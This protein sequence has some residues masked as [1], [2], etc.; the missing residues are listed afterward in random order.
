M[1]FAFEV[2]YDG[3]PNTAVARHRSPLDIRVDSKRGMPI[4]DVV[5]LTLQQRD[6][7]AA[8]AMSYVSCE[9]GHA[10]ARLITD[11]HVTMMSTHSISSETRPMTVTL[12]PLSPR[13][14]GSASI[15]LSAP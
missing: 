1:R 14:F 9:Q 5:P 12:Q 13:A 11:R 8:V 7:T 6:R 3:S 4:D 15:R 10:L 2:E